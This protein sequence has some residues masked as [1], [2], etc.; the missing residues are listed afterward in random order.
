M[1]DSAWNTP[2]G[3]VLIVASLLS[4]IGG[5]VYA[6]SLVSPEQNLGQTEDA[7]AASDMANGMEM[8]ADINTEDMNAVD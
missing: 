3:R 4:A 8:N 1:R 6:R 5:C 2:F 7:N